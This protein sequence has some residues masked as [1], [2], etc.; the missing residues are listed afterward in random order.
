MTAMSRSPLAPPLRLEKSLNQTLAYW[1]PFVF[2]VYVSVVLWGAETGRSFAETWVSRAKPVVDTAASLNP[3]I[4]L[5]SGRLEQQG[6]PTDAF[7][8]A[9]VVGVLGALLGLAC[10]ILATRR[11]LRKAID[12]THKSTVKIPWLIPVLML[13]VASFVLCVIIAIPLLFPHLLVVASDGSLVL[14]YVL[15]VVLF[16][17]LPNQISIVLH[18]AIIWI[19]A[20]RHLGFGQN[21]VDDT[22]LGGSPPEDLQ[23]VRA[24]K[25]SL[26]R[27]LLLLGIGPAYTTLVA[28]WLFTAPSSAAGWLAVWVEPIEFLKPFAPMPD[29]S[30]ELRKLGGTVWDQLV[31]SHLSVTGQLGAIIPAML[32]FT[33]GVKRASMFVQQIDKSKKRIP[34]RALLGIVVLIIICLVGLFNPVT[35]KLFPVVATGVFVDYGA[36][37]F[38]YSVVP[39][40][41][42]ASLFMGAVLVMMRLS[43]T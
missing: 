24:E 43:R 32:I 19:I 11:P 21:Q 1:M 8:H 10:S 13:W 28:L 7:E 26:L 14:V 22:G 17:A 36:V 34:L 30:D 23:R 40:M 37:I 38:F 27:V 20:G 12:N 9:A 2:T 4:S 39:V 3:I 5:Y 41:T 25:K 42:V 15:A 16:S 33:K 29:R 6:A 31:F 35:T 18:Q